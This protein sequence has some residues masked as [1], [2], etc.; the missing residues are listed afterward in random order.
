MEL[1]GLLF[2]WPAWA[3]SSKVVKTNICEKKHVCYFCIFPP[4]WI[5]CFGACFSPSRNRPDSELL[6]NFHRQRPARIIT[7]HV[8]WKNRWS[9]RNPKKGV[10][11]FLLEQVDVVVLMFF[12]C[13]FDVFFWQISDPPKKWKIGRRWKVL[14]KSSVS[15]H[16]V[17]L[18]IV[19]CEKWF[20]IQK[21]VIQQNPPVK[22]KNQNFP[23]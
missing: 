14:L 1:K 6:G 23:P 16:V 20:N 19:R 4:F 10:S 3:F 18:D 21:A 2:D 8:S 17:L 13:F 5:F 9:S 11:V 22:S 12:C 15:S 7:D